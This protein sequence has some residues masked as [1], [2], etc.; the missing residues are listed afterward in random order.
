[1]DPDFASWQAST[2]ENRLSHSKAYTFQFF[3]TTGFAVG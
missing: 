2:H 3:Y 1:M